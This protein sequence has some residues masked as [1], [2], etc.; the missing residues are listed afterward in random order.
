MQRVEGL[1]RQ[2]GIH[3]R[4]VL[5]DDHC[6]TGAGSARSVQRAGDAFPEIAFT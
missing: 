3:L 2:T 1:S 6:L 4:A 5:A